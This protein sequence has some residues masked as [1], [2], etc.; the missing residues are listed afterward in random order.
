MKQT[1]ITLLKKIFILL[2]LAV[3]NSIQV[4]AQT[5]YKQEL[6]GVWITNVDSDVLNSKEK[7]AEAMDYLAKQGFNVV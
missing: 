6:R 2:L 4:Q 5:V 3:V 7:L 1:S